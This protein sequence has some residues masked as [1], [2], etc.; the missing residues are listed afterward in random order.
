[1]QHER[2]HRT[3]KAETTR[4]AGRHSLEQQE[5]FDVFREEFNNERP[6]EALDGKAPAKVYTPA[7]KQ[8]IL[9]IDAC[10]CNNVE[11]A[12][13]IGPAL[14]CPAAVLERP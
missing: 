13:E 9:S 1:M 12:E 7:A 6:H 5:R 3:L 10:N 14:T 2:M 8:D 11:I 4:P